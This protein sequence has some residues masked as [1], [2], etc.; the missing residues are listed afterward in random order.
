MADQKEV[1]RIVSKAVQDYEKANPG[2]T[3]DERARRHIRRATEDALDKGES[4]STAIAAAGHG[5]DGAVI[6][7][8]SRAGI[9]EVFKSAAGRV[10]LPVTA[11]FGA[12]DAYDAAEK[13]N[14]AGV[15]E[16]IG[17]T[18]GTILAAVG[19]GAVYGSVFPGGGTLVGAGVGLVAGVGGYFLGKWTGGSLSRAFSP[20][21]AGTA[22]A[23]SMQVTADASRASPGARATDNK[24][25]I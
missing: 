13:G 14:P 12:W 4:V 5:I 10:L 23:S 3:L 24:P 7:N 1:D 19:A 9:T 6:G 16:A 20:A 2:Q 15:G 11:A 25:T 8:I 22:S 18:A 21:A 17:G